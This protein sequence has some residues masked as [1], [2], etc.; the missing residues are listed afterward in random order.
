MFR[1][2]YTSNDIALR[3]EELLEKLIARNQWKNAR[4]VNLLH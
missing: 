2:V 1:T 3:T 4:Y